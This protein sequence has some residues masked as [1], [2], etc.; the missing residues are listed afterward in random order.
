[1]FSFAFKF[2]SVS[3]YPTIHRL[4]VPI[5]VDI[6]F[7]TITYSLQTADGVVVLYSASIPKGY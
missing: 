7:P 6:L 1:M 2:T 5:I 4:F 3:F